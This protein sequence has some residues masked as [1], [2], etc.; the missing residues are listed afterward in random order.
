M[1][2]KVDLQSDRETAAFDRVRG[3][4]E[5]AVALTAA[6]VED[7]TGL[8]LPPVITVRL[9]TPAGFKE[10]NARRSR[11]LRGQRPGNSLRPMSRV[12]SAKVV[13]SASIDAGA[14]YG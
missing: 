10:I 4:V 13:V 7:V 3:E 14:G 2:I 11:F 8:I 5:R 9:T 1:T 6:A 12:E